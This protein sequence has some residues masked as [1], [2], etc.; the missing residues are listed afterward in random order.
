ML[1]LVDI[2]ATEIS[3]QVAVELLQ[4]PEFLAVLAVLAVLAERITGEYLVV[5]LV[6]LVLRQ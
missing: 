1:L 6:L 3:L 2:H 4:V 5:L